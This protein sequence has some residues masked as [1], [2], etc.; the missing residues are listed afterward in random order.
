MI[1]SH[2]LS[3]FLKLLW[4]CKKRWRVCTKIRLGSYVNCRMV[5]AFWRSSGSTNEKR[6]SWKLKMQGG[7]A[8]LVVRGYSRRK[9]LTSMKFFSPVV[10]HTSI[11]VL[12]AFVALFDLEFEQLDGKTTFLHEDLKEEIYMRQSEGFIVPGKE[13]HVPCLKKSLYRLK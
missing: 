12:F 8:Q 10:H 1:S 2:L 3:Q 13:N 9:V 5:T 7:K 6:A 4:Q 11:R